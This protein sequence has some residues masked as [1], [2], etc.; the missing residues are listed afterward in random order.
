MNWIVD[1][2]L[3]PESEL[4]FNKLGH[5]LTRLDL[6]EHMTVLYEEDE[7]VEAD[8][9]CSSCYEPYI[10]WYVQVGDINGWTTFT[11]QVGRYGY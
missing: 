1:N 5:T 7:V 6:I 3:T 4:T 11:D 8:C 2:I 10:T 9:R